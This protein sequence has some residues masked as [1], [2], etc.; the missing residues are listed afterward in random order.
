MQL[1]RGLLFV[2]VLVVTAWPFIKF[3]RQKI[4]PHES[5]DLLR[6]LQDSSKSISLKAPTTP[7]SVQDHS[8]TQILDW[9][10]FEKKFGNQLSKKVVE[11]RV[12]RI[13]GRRS[14]NGPFLT[15]SSKEKVLRRAQE[16]LQAS[17]GVM[18]FEG[19]LGE[20]KVALGEYS[21]HVVWDQLVDGVP[22]VPDGDL[23]LHLGQRGE[24]L[25]LFSRLKSKVEILNER[26]LS[27]EQV[28][29]QYSKR[30]MVGGPL[31]V[32][33]VVK[34]PSVHQAKVRHAYE[35]NLDGHQVIVD[36]QDGKI[37]FER[38]QR[39]H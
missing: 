10:A 17:Q 7:L 1:I 28:R 25:G 38:D 24:I 31:A 35:M 12:V 23:T 2:V 14:S 30:K 34:K 4:A 20:P 32:A 19:Q 33:W 11:G 37:I 29:A 39:R 16:V 18:N 27:G 22:L 36:A 5:S 3:A 15:L 6:G 8:Q 9:D 13:Q 21:A 26:I